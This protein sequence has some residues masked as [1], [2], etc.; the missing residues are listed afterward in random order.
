M[1]T[2]LGSLIMTSPPRP[3]H[4]VTY[5]TLPFHIRLY[6]HTYTPISPT[7]IPNLTPISSSFSLSLSL[8]SEQHTH[9][10][11]TTTTTKSILNAQIHRPPPRANR[12]RHIQPIHPKQQHTTR[13]HDRQH[14]GSSRQDWRE[15]GDQSHPK[16]EPQCHLICGCNRTTV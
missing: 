10:T 12:R 14:D 7:N 1:Y 2:P 15:E 4:S 13:Q 11:T 8:S 16:G 9:T 3:S 6:K 5:P